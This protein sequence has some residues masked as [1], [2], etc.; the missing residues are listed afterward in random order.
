MALAYVLGGA[1]PAV[2]LSRTEPAPPGLSVKPLT[3]EDAAALKP[4]A[5][6][7][8]DGAAKW[9][10]DRGFA[11]FRQARN[12]VALYPGQS[13]SILLLMAPLHATDQAAQ[14]AAG[15]VLAASAVLAGKTTATL[16]VLLEGDPDRDHAG[17]QVFAKTFSARGRIVATMGLGPLPVSDCGL[18]IAG[19]GQP[20]GFAPVWLRQTAAG[21]AQAEGRPATAPTGVIEWGA[22]ATGRSASGQGPLVAAGVPAVTYVC[23]GSGYASRNVAITSGLHAARLA[24]R[25][26][27]TLDAADFPPQ[28]SGSLVTMAAGTVISAGR[29]G[30]AATMA[31]MPLWMGSLLALLRAS[32]RPGATRLAFGRFAVRVAPMLVALLGIV[33]L[34][35]LGGWPAYP[36]SPD[37]QSGLPPLAPL[38]WVCVATLIAW[39]GLLPARRFFARIAGNA[40][41]SA[42]GPAELAALSACSALAIAFNPFAA[43][44]LLLPAAWLMPAAV[45]GPGNAILTLLGG[46][47]VLA[48][49]VG[50]GMVTG[51]GW[52]VAPL[53][54]E[55]L[56]SGGWS[57]AGAVAGILALAA[58]SGG[59]ARSFR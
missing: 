4:V 28:E 50:V 46:T 48:L 45:G 26:V 52:R 58:G 27:R 55:T 21:V 53:F 31:F 9:F 13:D 38:A 2:M 6:P 8:R 30:A 51:S 33:L 37:F 23:A 40:G 20:T 5:V 12:V 1:I 22:R 42:R 57:A 43:V 19:A 59:V 14:R 7:G 24:V 47:G 10:A 32:R 54:V 36:P 17:A 15:A 3:R 11:V 16:G 39:L 18:A 49:A 25:F 44:I 41:L 35:R 34:P 29:F 56:A